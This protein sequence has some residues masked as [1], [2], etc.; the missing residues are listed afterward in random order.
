MACA[1]MLRKSAASLIP[2]AGRVARVQSNFHAPLSA[3]LTHAFVSLNPSQSSF[4]RS[5]DFSTA[6]NMKKPSSDDF[7]LP[8]IESEIQCAEESGHYAP[9]AG[10]PSGFPFKI[11]DRPGLQIITLRREY[12]GETIK[13]DVHM[14]NLVTGEENDDDDDNNRKAN[15]SC[16]PLVVTVSKKSGLNLEFQ[17]VALPDE[18]SIDNLAVRNSDIEY[19]LSYEGPDFHDLDENLQKVFHKYLEIRGVKPSTTNFLHEYM[20]EKDRREYLIWLKNLKK[21]VEA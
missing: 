11:E 21:F 12:D 2:L 16:L 19:Q 5:L 9:I 10:A 8:V 3:A 7:L 20:I 15:Q 6:A 18:I 4:L 1:S 13:V 14:S 17:C